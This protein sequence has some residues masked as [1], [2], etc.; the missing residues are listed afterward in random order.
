[1]KNSIVKNYF[2]SLSYVKYFP[3]IG[4]LFVAES[5]SENIL[6]KVRYTSMKQVKKA[7]TVVISSKTF[8]LLVGMIYNTC[9]KFRVNHNF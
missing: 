3:V 7:E 5:P 8:L 1:M 6:F 2:T 4:K 9:A